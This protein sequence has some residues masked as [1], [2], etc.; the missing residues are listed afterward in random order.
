MKKYVNGK[1][2]EMTEKDIA[3]RNSRIAKRN[4]SSDENKI[5]TLEETI[6]ELKNKLN[7]LESSIEVKT[8]SEV[9]SEQ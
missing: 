2:V 8:E 4:K 3:R 1:I 5:K 9:V 7:N 6:A